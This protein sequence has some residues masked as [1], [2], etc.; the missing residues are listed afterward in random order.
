MGKYVF[1]P[2]PS[3]RLGASLGVNNIPLKYC[4]YSCIYC[5]AGYTVNKI[6]CR[7][8]FYDPIEVAREVLQF[9]EKLNFE[10]DYVTFVPNGE[11]TLDVNLGRIIELIKSEVSVPIAVLTNASLIFMEAVRE[12]LQLADLVSVKVDSVIEDVW[13]KINRPHQDLRLSEILSGILEFSRSFNG[14]LI[15]ETMLVKGVNDH[16]HVLTENAKFISRIRGLEKAYI[17]VPV[18]PP[19]EKWVEIPSE[20]AIVKAFSIYSKFMGE[21]KVELL[22]G[23]ES[24][25]F[26]V[27]EDP[28]NYILS[29]TRVHPLKLD[30]AIKILGGGSEA[31]VAIEELVDKG[32]IVLVEYSGCKFILRKIQRST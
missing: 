31:E 9:L 24:G 15:T 4:T 1:G 28:V 6:A 18:R 12:D 2:V 16:E 23:I 17:S 26:R 3:R 7:R 11:P 5:Q 27:S 13:M 14:K 29:L 20:E 30:Y 21:N 25:E 10:V 8:K 19:T 32:K 22:T